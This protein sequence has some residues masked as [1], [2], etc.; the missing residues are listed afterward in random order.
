MYLK[1]NVFKLYTKWL[2]LPMLDGKINNFIKIQNIFLNVS[3]I[4]KVS[5]S[6][7]LIINCTNTLCSAQTVLFSLQV[8]SRS[9]LL[10]PCTGFALFLKDEGKPFCV[11][12]C[13]Q[14]CFPLLL[15]SLSEHN[16]FFL[17]EPFS[18]EP[19]VRWTLCLFWSQIFKRLVHIIIYTHPTVVKL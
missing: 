10:L 19:R 9:Y 18:W 5:C 8:Q 13:I 16:L 7:Q 12:I 3:S 17:S 11:C 14:D 4:S 15:E 1:L 6:L 2:T